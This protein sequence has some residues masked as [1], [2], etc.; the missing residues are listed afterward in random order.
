MWWLLIWNFDTQSFAIAFSRKI[1][2]QLWYCR[3]K[4]GKK[5]L[6]PRLITKNL[7]ACNSTVEFVFFDLSTWFTFCVK[8]HTQ[9]S[10]K[11]H[12]LAEHVTGARKTRKRIH[13]YYKKNIWLYFSII[14]F[15]AAR[16]LGLV[17]E[18]TVQAQAKLNKCAL[19]AQ[20]NRIAIT[21]MS[22]KMGF[23]KLGCAN[24]KHSAEW[25]MEK[26]K[27]KSAVGFRSASRGHKINTQTITCA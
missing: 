3:G 4:Q 14:F 27:K 24:W 22:K 10:P 5:C 17:R 18:E 26:E 8:N 23:H 25:A 2:F 12:V 21:K 20:P 9:F 1:R 6:H 13:S 19:L 7:L 16:S 15:E 11:F